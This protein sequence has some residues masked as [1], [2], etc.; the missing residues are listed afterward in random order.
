MQSMLKEL[1][2]SRTKQQLVLHLDE[3]ASIRDTYIQKNRH[4]YDD[5]LKFFIYNIPEGSSV[6]EIGCGTGYLLNA[7]NPAKGVGIDLSFNMIHTA[8]Q[9]YPNLEFHRMDAEAL[10][11]H[12]VFDI[13]IISDT[14]GFFEDIQRVFSQLKKVITPDTRIILTYHN[15]F[16]QPLLILA[17]WLR[18]KM[19][20]KRLN[21]LDDR[22]VANLLKLEGFEIIKKGKR[23]ICPVSLPGISWLC[24]TYLG[25]LPLL[26]RVCITGYTIA[27]MQQKK[28]G[29]APPYNVSV[30]VP[31]RNEK[32]N[33]EQALQR[34]PA[35]GRQT[36]VI[37][38]EGH[39]TDKTLEE[40]QRV[41]EA[42]SGVLDVRYI[43]QDGTGKGD[44]V[45]KGF[46][47]ATGDILMI[48]DADLT[49]APEELPKF[50]QA[51]ATG[52]GEYINGSRLVYPMEDEAMRF[53]NMLGNKF[54]SIMFSFLLEQ[55]LKDT[56][57]GTKV[58]F[59]KHYQ[60]LINNRKY[61]G[62]FDPFGDFDLI[63]GAAKLNLQIV[64]I[65]IRYGARTYGT[66]N[67]SRF[68]HGWLLL[69]MVIFA[70]NKIKF[71]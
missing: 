19:P 13:V 57:C 24:N 33:I 1:N 45:R 65:P 26:N 46:D 25:H 51:I 31:A 14:L 67:I 16:W 27:R 53:L 21:W 49:V 70:M 47:I 29:N 6:L 56:L 68:T 48:L 36:E 28:L 63:F 71:V 8:K 12:D 62:D 41:C 11:L 69:K 50:Y 64:E 66:T 4:Y 35:M 44:A 7:I 9:R 32:G 59:K 37:F 55:P 30:I 17:E 54:F 3:M 18:L 58:I 61:F 60:Q 39:S 10:D 20:Q 22:D 5:L 42:Y 38:V 52:R 43:V 40:I 2:L 15:F 34:I 23:F